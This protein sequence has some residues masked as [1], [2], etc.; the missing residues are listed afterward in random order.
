MLPIHAEGLTFRSFRDSD[1]A[2]FACAV[3]ES[4]ETV[5]RWMPWCTATF[6]EE[7]ALA[8]FRQ[9]RAR[10][11]NKTGV[12]LGVFCA[13]TGALLGGAGLNGIQRQYL[14]CNLGYWVRQTAQRQGIALRTVRALVPYAFD[15]LG[16]QRVEI[17]VAQGNVASEAVARKYGAHFEGMARNRMHL[18][19]VA[20]SASMFSVI[21]SPA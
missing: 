8:W 2:D 14:L 20:V 19:G 1:A 12:E 15:V 4:V 9:C 16:L 3:R 21:P 11:R 5:G 17:V 10:K 13:Q 18:H 6:S 7:Q